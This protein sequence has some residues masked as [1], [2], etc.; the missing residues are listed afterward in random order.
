MR[1]L[2][3]SLAH[4]PWPFTHKQKSSTIVNMASSSHSGNDGKSMAEIDREGVDKFNR[5]LKQNIER[6]ER[7]MR[8]WEWMGNKL[9]PMSIEHMPHERNR[10]SGSGMTAEDRVLRKQWVMDQALAPNEPRVIP[11]LNPKNPIR[12]AFAVPWNVLFKTLEPM[13]VC[14]QMVKCK[15]LL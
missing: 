15:Q 4:R 11:E 9:P 1:I 8:H 2:V 5:L 10:L 7:L 12:R 14:Q 13:L 6:E 3:A